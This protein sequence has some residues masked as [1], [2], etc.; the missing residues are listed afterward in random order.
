MR[1]YKSL[2]L[3]VI[4]FDC[5]IERSKF[6]EWWFCLQDNVYSCYQRMQE[7]EERKHMTPPEL[8]VSGNIQP[9]V[10]SGSGAKRRLSFDDPDSP[11]KRMR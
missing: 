9:A 7:I 11:A 10:A 2:C 3:C 6:D 1:M 5:L 8:A 4:D